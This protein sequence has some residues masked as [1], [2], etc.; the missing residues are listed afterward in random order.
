MFGFPEP[1]F[2]P[3]DE[4]GASVA[5]AER[6]RHSCEDGRR[7]DY[8]VLQHHGEIEAF[9]DELGRYLESPQGRFEA[10]DAERRRS[11]EQ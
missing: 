1:R 4:C 5:R 2:M 11:R 10:W 9:D 3:C 6:A 7:L 8:L